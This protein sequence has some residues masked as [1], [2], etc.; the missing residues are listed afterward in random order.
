MDFQFSDNVL[1][2]GGVN[3]AGGPIDP[4]TGKPSYPAG[5]VVSNHASEVT[6]VIVGQGSAAPADIGIAP[7]AT[8]LEAGQTGSDTSANGICSLMQQALVME[9]SRF[10][11]SHVANF[12]NLSQGG[13]Y[14]DNNNRGQDISSQFVD[15]AAARYNAVITIAGNERGTEVDNPADAFNGITVGATGSRTNYD[16][17]AANLNVSLNGNWNA[18]RTADGRIGVSLVAPGGDPGPSANNKGNIPD[19]TNSAMKL[20][21]FDNQFLT[22][23]GGQFE[24]NP[25]LTRQVGNNVYDQ[26]TFDGTASTAAYGVCNGWAPGNTVVG[27]NLCGTSFAAPLVAGAADLLQ[28]YADNAISQPGGNFCRNEA[29]PTD[30]RVLKA[31]LLNGASK[32]NSD[33]TPLMR[34]ADGANAAIPWTRT[35][36]SQGFKPLPG[37]ALSEQRFVGTVHEV[38]QSGLDPQLGTGQLNLVNSLKNYAPGEQGPGAPGSANVSSIGWDYEV[39]PANS[40]ISTMYMYNF[41]IDFPCPGFQA[42]LVWDDP[43]SITNQGSNNSWQSTSTLSRGPLAANGTLANFTDLDLYL[44]QI[45]ADS[46]MT[47]LGWSTSNVDNVQHVYPVDAA[48]NS[49]VLAAG[50]YQLDVVA[51]NPVGDADVPYGLAWGFVAVPEPASAGMLGICFIAL[52][53]RRRRVA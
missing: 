52:F 47:E 22:T 3:A 49:L 34:S 8:V 25:E 9:S 23:A 21:A 11:N 50:N 13:A 16:Q 33:G 31:L 37:G 14:P 32:F 43:V 18:N 4:K 26:D 10:V 40:L 15:W 20:P 27:S 17:A 5:L 28:E 41:S 30:H 1:P 7:A 46:T 39:V 51:A 12:L 42:T 6:G 44:F 45:N 2:A 35:T 38:A 53:A 36:T 19:P 24:L 48:G 29:D